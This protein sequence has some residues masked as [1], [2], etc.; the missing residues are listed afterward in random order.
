[1]PE[2]ILS[3]AVVATV[4]VIMFDIGLA[5]VPGEFRWV[6][7]RPGLMA[8]ALF[9]VLVAVPV[10][11]FAIG[12]ALQVPHAAEVGIVLMAISP[13]AP[14]ALRRS[15]G[16]GA[17]RSFAPALQIVV[18][19]LAVVSMPLSIAAL[20]EFYA[21]SA[22]ISPW[23]LAKQVFTVQLLPLGLGML[24]RQL[25][26]LER[27]QWLAP[28]LARVGTW[29]LVAVVL[30]IL[31]EIWGQIAAAGLRVAFAIV[32]VTLASLAV[33]DRLGGPDA[34]TRTA[35]A[36][37]SAARNGGL[38]LLVATLNSAQPAIKATVLAYVVI[39]A[40]TVAPYVMWR[41]RAAP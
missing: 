40:F 23:Q 30:L 21:G 4:F 33:G 2:W 32:L 22:S 34:A 6:W 12:R 7:Q 27:A 28:R 17:H 35:T 13:G 20:D 29:L 24:A 39:S 31:Y 37:C 15:L 36:I 38:A 25:V 14:V 19:A 10:L 9:S 41:R 26:G 16:A 11:A 1:M 18:A 8:R 5:I 3:A